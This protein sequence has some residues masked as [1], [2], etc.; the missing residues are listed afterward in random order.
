[1]IFR[2]FCYGRWRSWWWGAALNI[3]EHWLVWITWHGAAMLPPNKNWTLSADARSIGKKSWKR[4]RGQGRRHGRSFALKMWCFLLKCKARSADQAGL[5][6]SSHGWYRANGCHPWQSLRRQLQLARGPWSTTR[7]CW[8]SSCV[9][10]GSRFSCSLHS[11]QGADGRWSGAKPKQNC[12]GLWVCRHDNHHTFFQQILPLNWW[13]SQDDSSILRLSPQKNPKH[14]GN[15]F[16][17]ILGV[18]SDLMILPHVFFRIFFPHVAVGPGCPA[19]FFF[20]EDAI[21]LRAAL[22]DPSVPS[23]HSH[24]CSCLFRE[25]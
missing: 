6:P 8:W 16:R 2:G 24:G 1:M 7:C 20:F 17:W 4:K 3:I 15:K 14:F 13:L 18:E 9:F 12:T 19:V 22:A 25:S 5:E 10:F 21:S 11:S 23:L